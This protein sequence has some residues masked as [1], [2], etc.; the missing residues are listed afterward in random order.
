MVDLTSDVPAAA[1]LPDSG[2]TADVPR[3]RVCADNGAGAL[4]GWL[5][6]F[7]LLDGQ[8]DWRCDGKRQKERRVD[9]QSDEGLY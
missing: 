9:I 8:A 1:G 5:A 3:R 6:G 4:R 2:R 7:H